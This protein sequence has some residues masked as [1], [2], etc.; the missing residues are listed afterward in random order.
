MAVARLLGASGMIATSGLADSQLKLY[1]RFGFAV[2]PDTQAY[3]P[4]YDEDVCV[5]VHRTGRGAGEYERLVQR[6]CRAL[7]EELKRV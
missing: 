6:L 1:Q 5:I 2:S 3:V 4:K 7:G